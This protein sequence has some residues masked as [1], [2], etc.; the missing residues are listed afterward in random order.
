MKRISKPSS[1][2]YTK[3]FKPIR[4][5][6]P[7]TVSYGLTNYSNYRVASQIKIEKLEEL[8]LLLFNSKI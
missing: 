4:S 2:I 8:D 6:F 7:F 3:N 5:S 1:K